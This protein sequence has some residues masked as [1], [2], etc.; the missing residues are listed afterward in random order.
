MAQS[1]Q[2]KTDPTGYSERKKKDR[3]T[4]LGVDKQKKPGLYHDGRGLY[5]QVTSTGAKTWVLRYMLR[6]RAREMGLGSYNQDVSLADAREK[7]KEA[8]KLGKQGIDPIENRKAK[9]AAQVVAE[10]RAIT[11]DECCDGYV[12][13]HEKGWGAD[14]K[15]VWTNSVRDYVTPVFGKLPVAMVDTALV[16]KVLKPIWTT[17]HE[18]AR[19]LRAR[20][21]S[22]LDWAQA[23]HYRER[24]NPA[25]WKGHLD[26]ILDKPEN[27]HIVKHHPALP[28]REVGKLIAELRA[29]DD[30]DARCLELLILTV[31]RVDAATRAQA[32]EFDLKERVWTIPASRMKRRGKRK[33]TP[34]RV[35]LSEVAIAVV[36]RTGIKKGPL[37][38]HCRDKS[39]AK[40]HGREDITTH[41]FRSTFRDW[42]GEETTFQREVIEMAMAHAI[43]DE[44]EEAYAR[45]DLFKKRRDLMDAWAVYCAN[46]DGDA[47]SADNV[48]PF[49]SGEGAA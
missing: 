13:D 27:I 44:T 30:R 43:G 5:L 1:D 17:R 16:L 20:I 34:F 22:V 24:E 23:Q 14:H 48:V 7:A 8:R 2:E 49:R 12:A 6:G 32:E 36:Q 19:R 45:G 26:K 9:K 15:R 29:R 41:G 38:P 3:L 11:F 46:P 47:K 39:L 18:T 10:A 25:R 35:P 33:A 31:T 40:A 42:A 21:E 28:Y 37:F 4:A